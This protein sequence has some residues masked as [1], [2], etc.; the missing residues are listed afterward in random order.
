[1][2]KSGY[3]IQTYF[4][5][6]SEAML[7]GIN[8]KIQMQMAQ[9]ERTGCSVILKVRKLSS[10][11]IKKVLYRLPFLRPYPKY[12]LDTSFHDCDFIYIRYICADAQFISFLKRIKKENTHCKILIEMPS[13]PYDSELKSS[14][15]NRSIYWR[16]I[17][18]RKKLHRYVD[19]AVIFVQASNVFHMPTICTI[20]GIDV[21]A[22]VPRRV[23]TLDDSLH[24]LGIANLAFWHGY[25][26]FIAGLGEYYRNGGTKN[27]VFHIAGDTNSKAGKQCMALCHVHQVCDHVVFYGG[28]QGKAL[29]ALYDQCD[30][31]IEVLGGHRKDIFVSSS[32]KSR[33][34]LAK[35][36]PML[37]SC[38][39][40]I[41]SADYSYLLSVP[42]DE[43]PVDIDRL[44]HFVQNIYPTQQAAE[45]AAKQIRMFAKEH[46]DI[47]QTMRPI[48]EWLMQV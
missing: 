27:I 16:D 25:D 4:E 20:N 9:M 38:R 14:W 5:N 33:E 1:M 18:Y 29:D 6:T 8:Q 42:A 35:G 48:T 39:I 44:L 30:I 34:F 40:D 2:K 47:S 28:M 45:E 12:F 19:A 23:R 36:L 46:C 22:I 26:R 31:G 21:D 15:S 32:L 24:V 10:S 17:Y 11:L 3:Y 13:Y 37:T 43:S 41:L 7:S